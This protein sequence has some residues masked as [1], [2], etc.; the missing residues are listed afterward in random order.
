MNL[1]SAVNRG[2]E[3]EERF[4]VG[5]EVGCSKRFGREFYAIFEVGLVEWF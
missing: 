4:G 5:F 2:F 3:Y 1:K